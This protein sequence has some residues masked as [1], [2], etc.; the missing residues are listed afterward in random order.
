MF[1]DG[2]RWVEQRPNARP[3]P[4]RHRLRD[5]LATI[6]IMLLIPT[7]V[8]PF[9]SA[10]ARTPSLQVSGVA[11]P[12]AT[13]G[14]RGSNFTSRDRIQL[15]WDASSA[16]MPDVRVDGRGNFVIDVV[17]PEAASPGFHTVAAATISKTRSVTR[18]ST[19]V[20]SA[21]VSV[22]STDSTVASS[23]APVVTPPPA[24]PVPIVE[25]DPTA[26]PPTAAPPTPP[27]STATPTAAPTAPPTA[28]PTAPPTAA[29]T[30]PPTAAPAPTP[31]PTAPPAAGCTATVASGGNIQAAL[32]A[33]AN[34]GTLCLTGSYNLG[35]D[36]IDII[37]RSNITIDGRGAS[38]TASG[39]GPSSGVFLIQDSQHI[40]IH[41]ATL[42][43]TNANGGTTSAYHAGCEDQGGV[44]V[45]GASD[46]EAYGLTVERTNGECFYVDRGGSPRGTGAWA[47]GVVFRDSTCRFNG[48]MAVAIAGG[49]HVTVQRV[50][51]TKIAISV[52][53]IEPYTATGGGTYVNFVDNVINGYGLS[54]TYTG[55]ILEADAMNGYTTTVVHDVTIARNTINVGA[56][57]SANTVTTAGLAIKVREQRR[58][59]IS[60]LNNVSAVAGSGPAIYFEHVDGATV[61]G[62]T[63]PLTS[64]P[65]VWMSDCSGISVS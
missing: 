51:F 56:T 4:P 64:G 27:A 22:T 16:G 31:A 7:L 61:S 52:L 55:W 14:V 5:W 40:K 20:A 29:P 8:L 47:D 23:A 1:W 34:G 65:L 58:Q 39:C 21:T 46:V 42:A 17:V 48:R 9:V 59:N 30:A 54:P 49:S 11:T 36:G 50:T 24:A 41:D 35:S 43:G 2:T 62:N 3:R 18:L 13:L 44:M 28:A 37:G 26:L 60:I 63:Q 53:D 38:I 45:Y 15:L 57:I 25:V 12:G 33:L 10:E 19:Y 6:P 32:N